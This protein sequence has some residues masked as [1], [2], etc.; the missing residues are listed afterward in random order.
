[1]NPPIT[2][3]SV[4]VPCYNEADNVDKLHDELLPILE[5]LVNGETALA[6]A[7]ESVE[8]VVVDDGSRDETYRTLKQQFA[9]TQ[10]KWLTIQIVQH[11]VNRG[12]GAAIRTGFG[13][14]TGDVIVTTDSDGTYRFE[15]IPALLSCLTPQVSIVT[16]SPYHPDGRVMNVPAHRLI[17]S[18]GS[19]LLYRILVSWR[20]HTYTALFRA[21]RR[22]VVQRI[23][24]ESDGF[25]A[26][27]ELMVHAM[28]EGYRV[29]E[30]PTTLYSRENGVSK[31]KIVRTI[32]AHLKFQ[33]EILL[34][35]LE[36]RRNN[37]VLDTR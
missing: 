30:Y 36:I 12:L 24:F 27:T 14:A 19:S 25:L 23:P 22:E 2:K 3:L 31:A 26:G 21:Y 32:R 5:K 29:A 13:A 18:R 28:L 10:E 16:A 4:V 8:L 34:R 11:A 35:R 1:M 17:F 33:G 20:I 7:V 37:L 15:E 6:T 9:G